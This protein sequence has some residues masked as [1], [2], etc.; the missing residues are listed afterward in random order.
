MGTEERREEMKGADGRREG[1]RRERRIRDEKIG[2]EE[3]KNN[4]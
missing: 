1:G 4:N 3:I 2:K